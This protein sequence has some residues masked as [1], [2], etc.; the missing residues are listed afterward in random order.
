MTL[1]L[2]LFKNGGFSTIALHSQP[3]ARNWTHGDV[4]IRISGNPLNIFRLVKIVASDI[5]RPA[6]APTSTTG[7]FLHITINYQLDSVNCVSLI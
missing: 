2:N 6:K 5:E 3:R 4:E 7:P 1:R